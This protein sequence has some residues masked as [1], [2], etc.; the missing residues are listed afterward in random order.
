M[1][2]LHIQTLGGFQVWRDDEAV[3]PTAWKTQKTRSLFAI[4]LTYRNRVLSQDQLIEWLWPD[5]SLDSA[6]NSLQVA[7]S[8][9]RRVLEPGLRRPADSR[10][11]LTHPPGYRLD[12]SRDCWVDADEFEAHYRQAVGAEQRGDRVAALAHYREAATHYRGDYLPEEPY[13]DWAIAER[14]RLLELYLDL[15]ERQSQ[16][17]LES[18]DFSAA[19]QA[20][21]Q[22]LERDPLRERIYRRLMRYYY[23][24]GDRAAALAMFDR[25]RQVLADELGVEPLAQTLALRDAIL[26]STLELAEPHPAAPPRTFGAFPTL[27]TPFVGRHREM[28]VLRGAWERVLA[29]HPHFVLIRGEVGV[30]K[31]RL[32]AE[33][34]AQLSR[35]GVQVFQTRSY[36]MES[37]LLYRPVLELSNA[38]LPKRRGSEVVS[39]LEPF[40][41][42]LAPLIPHLHKLSPAM[43]AHQ[44]VPPE[45]ER[46]RVREGL[47]QCLRLTAGDRPAV[48]I[49]EDLQWADSS[50]LDLLQYVVRTAGWGVAHL[51]VATY[52]PEDIDRGHPI[53][54]LRRDLA[55]AD[56]LTEIELRPLLPGEIAALLGQMAGSP[57]SGVRLARRLYDETEGNPFYLV[58]ILRALFEAGVIWIDSSGRWRTDYDEITE[59]YQELMLPETVREVTLD[60]LARLNPSE[61]DW[62][63]A[64][65]VIGRPFEF[66]L[67]RAATGAEGDALLA[68]IETYERRQLLSEGEDGRYDF[69]HDK[70]REVLYEELNTVRRRQLHA[71]IA[72][73]MERLGVGTVEDLAHHY[74]EAGVADRAVHYLLLAGDRA[75]RLGASLEAI[76]FYQKALQ[77]AM[78]AVAPEQAVELHAI[79]ER[80]GDAYL[81]DLSRHD[82]ALE[83]YMA[84]LALAQ[85]DED[86]ARGARKIADVHLLR[87]DLLEA[88]NHYEIALERL[89]GFPLL[90][91]TSRVHAKLSYLLISRGLLDEAMEHARASLEIS[92][93]IDDVRGLADANR[94]LGIIAKRRGELEVACDHHQRSLDLYRD[95]G[96]LPR[97]AQACNNVADSYRLWGEMDRALEYLDEGLK[98]ARRIGDTRDEALLLTTKAE[99]YLDQGEWELA[100]EQMK[101]AL[102]LAEASGMAARIIAAH[103][104]LGSAYIGVGQLE[105]ARRHLETAERLSQETQHLRFAPQI[106]LCMARLDAR[107]GQFDK[108]QAKAQL[109]LEYAGREPSDGFLGLWHRCCGILHSLEGRWEDAVS[110][111]ER[112]LEFLE[113]ANLPA[114]VG[115]TRLELG[116]A[117]ANRG[118]EGDRGRACEQLLAAQETFHQIRARPYLAQ[119][120]MQIAEL[121]CE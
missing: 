117:Y 57:E 5:L 66:E 71:Q 89:S 99:L 86:R 4:L 21:Q 106:Y 16:L 27:R 118:Q 114:E 10:F 29:G 69:D 76:D 93:K 20:C 54:A 102:P 63:A 47:A 48:V 8:N 79:H 95:L 121:A 13:A 100:I 24:S 19:I 104:T 41:P 38:Y 1:S 64:A 74:V 67:L 73:S 97:T 108:A 96:D 87:G 45:Q 60:R 61:Q 78:K 80:L 77:N 90:A 17:L 34:R 62:L 88:Q 98:I 82:D 53:Y 14:D 92:R 55:Q 39:Q 56:L 94:V 51:F 84:F 9:L 112:S 31:S 3:P 70:I 113:R 18:G 7:I 116:A 91:E 72:E 68:A 111:L 101:Q 33:F 52:R 75:R 65:A 109:A 119:A 15:L 12:L 26:H 30:G 103:W 23:M 25:C 32:V 43:P 6:R 37:G 2:R 36:E 107:E 83:H 110:H 120:E 44:P 22:I 59:S 50:T 46:Q 40:L 81:E 85:S 49:F 42:V 58:E 35:E 105:E 28:A 11:L 115:K